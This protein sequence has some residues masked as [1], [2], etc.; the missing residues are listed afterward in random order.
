MLKF[1]EYAKEQVLKFS[2]T[3][4]IIPRADGYYLS[5]NIDSLTV[6]DVSSACKCGWFFRND[7]NYLLICKELQFYA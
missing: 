7:E 1:E 2:P 4:H 5:L 6:T 3:L